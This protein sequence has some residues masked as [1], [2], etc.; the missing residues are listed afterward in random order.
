LAEL[1]PDSPELQLLAGRYGIH[2]DTLY[3]QEKPIFE[4]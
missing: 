2:L 1:H 3:R 4:E